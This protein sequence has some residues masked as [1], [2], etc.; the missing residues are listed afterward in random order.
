MHLKFERYEREEHFL[1]GRGI[2]E[3]LKSKILKTA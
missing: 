3:M 2:R 1:E